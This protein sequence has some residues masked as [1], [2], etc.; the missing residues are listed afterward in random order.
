VRLE[1]EREGYRKV[2]R[3]VALP[4]KEKV[5]V[6]LDRGCVV[7]G[8]LKIDPSL[9]P[10]DLRVTGKRSHDVSLHEGGA[11]EVEV[12][13]ETSA[14]TIEVDPW[15]KTERKLD[16]GCSGRVDLGTIEVGA[17]REIEV[18]V[19][20]PDASAVAA[21]RIFGHR[22]GDTA[23]GMTGPDGKARVVLSES[24]DCLYATHRAWLP[25][26]RQ[27]CPN[28]DARG[29]AVLTLEAGGWISGQV[30]ASRLGE[31][32]VLIAQPLGKGRG[33][34]KKEVVLDSTGSFRLGPVPPGRYELL[35]MAKGRVPDRDAAKI[36]GHIGKMVQVQAGKTTWVELGTPAGAVLS[37]T[38]DT[39]P[40]HTV[41]AILV[42]GAGMADVFQREGFDAVI[43]ALREGP[44]VLTTYLEGT[45][46][47]LVALQ[48]GRGRFALDE[49]HPGANLVMVFF[50][51][52]GRPLEL[53]GMPW[54][55]VVWL[56]PGERQR[57]DVVY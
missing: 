2:V 42:A 18:E 30:F 56:D 49:V 14:V 52:D 47:G 31:G 1:I 37:G 53:A 8:R 57:L 38:I 45:R 17:P 33:S 36:D 39:S 12:S 35:L 26:S 46:F 50:Y 25:S 24:E 55:D 27:A 15:L 4:A 32:N 5:R 11:F 48:N 16:Q 22:S 10:I 6:E 28:V 20:A 29:R 51:F 13:S 43:A 19:R 7:T 34:S 54:M 44:E 9:L 3:S 40:E 21:A 23:L 41:A